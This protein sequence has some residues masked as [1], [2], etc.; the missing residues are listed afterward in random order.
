LF[1]ISADKVR[2][3]KENTDY[4]ALLF[5][6]LAVAI[7]LIIAFFMWFFFLKK[8]LDKELERKRILDIMPMNM[9]TENR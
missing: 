6:V 4:I 2:K 8:Y 5:T 3:D 9:L 7:G 1:D